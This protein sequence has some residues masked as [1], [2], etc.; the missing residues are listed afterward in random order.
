MFGHC[1]S[2]GLSRINPKEQLSAINA[3]LACQD[4]GGAPIVALLGGGSAAV[5]TA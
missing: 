5:D 1:C 4:L 3:R 2:S